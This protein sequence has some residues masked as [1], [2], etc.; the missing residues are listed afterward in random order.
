MK[1]LAFLFV[2]P[3]F[4]FSAPSESQIQALYNSLDPKSVSE[5]LAF[6]K[7][8]PKNETGKKALRD[9]FF[10]LSQGKS[11]KAFNIGQLELTPAI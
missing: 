3:F 7:L 11:E 6:Y 2:C 5:H 9:A 1:K 10:L 8:Y 4:C